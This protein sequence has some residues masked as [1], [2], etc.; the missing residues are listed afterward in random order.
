MCHSNLT[1]D[2]I[3]IQH[4]GLVKIGTSEYIIYAILKH[5]NTD[6]CVGPIKGC[7]CYQVIITFNNIY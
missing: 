1:L 3:F 5:C 7:W 4:N 2:T 6:S